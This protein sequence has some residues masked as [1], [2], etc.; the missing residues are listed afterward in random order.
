MKAEDGIPA[1]VLEQTHQN[2]PAP[3]VPAELP[4]EQP[5]VLDDQ[6]SSDDLDMKLEE[7]FEDTFKES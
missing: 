2:Q 5:E 1:G 6:I 3:E 4:R 7:F